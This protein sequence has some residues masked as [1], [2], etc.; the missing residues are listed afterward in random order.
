MTKYI[1][2]HVS[3]AGG[4]ENSV[5]RAHEIGATTFALFLQ[6]QRR[7]ESPPLTKISK[8]LFKKNCQKY[9]YVSKYILPHSSYLINL[10]HPNNFLRK[11]SQF[12]FI[13]E[14]YRCQELGLSMLNFHP[15]SFL[16]K[17][18]EK[19]CLKNIIESINIV[20]NITK[21]ITIVIEN[22]A[23]QGSNVGYC[24]EHLAYIIRYVEDHTRI[25]VCLDSC[26][27]Y[28]S[29]YDLHDFTGILNTFKKFE[30]IVSF[31]YLKGL[32]L[33]DSLYPLRSRI[34]RHENLGKG[35]IKSFFFKWIMKTK[36]FQNIPIIL[37]TKNKNLW[38]SEIKWLKSL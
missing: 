3:S 21:D 28:A 19:K 13:K 22:T 8:I 12:F 23:G 30:E 26:H 37:E 14:I 6:N 5:L 25:G 31:K 1:G 29:G 20:L 17:I 4:V 32:H 24:F 15:G 18:S 38:S 35:Y 16:R 9:G 34:D 11:K 7:W 27:L 36:K 33:N 10:G 2:A